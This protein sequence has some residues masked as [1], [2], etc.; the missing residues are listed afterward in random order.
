MSPVAEA[1]WTILRQKNYGIPSVNMPLQSELQNAYASI[2]KK[3]GDAGTPIQPELPEEWVSLANKTAQENNWHNLTRGQ[4][5]N[6]GLCL[7]FGID[8]LIENKQLLLDFLSTC[9]KHK[10]KSLCRALIWTYLYH[11]SKH[12]PG[13]D[14]LGKWLS[15][16]VNEWDWS[17]ADRQKNLKLFGNENAPANISRAVLNIHQEVLTILDSCGLAKNLQSGGMAQ[18][19]FE[20][21]VSNFVSLVKNNEI[22]HV[23]PSLQRILD[24]AAL[25]GTQFSYPRLRD[26]F[27]SNLLEPW[28][29]NIP[30]QEIRKLIQNFL[31]NHF[32]DP[33]LDTSR[34]SG[35][36]D[37]ALNV[38]RS[39]LVERALAQFLDVVDELTRDADMK[40]QW[41]F[42]RAFW[43]SYYEKGF[44]SDAWVAFASNGGYQAKQIA[45]RNQ[46]ESW[47]S[48][49]RLNGQGDSNHAVLILRIGD[50]TV[51]DFSHNGKCRIWNKDNSHAPQPHQA[52]Y[53]R[54]NLTSRADSEFIHQGSEHA[55]WQ[56]KV[57]SEIL[58]KTGVNIS[59][60]EYM[61]K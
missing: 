18:S 51:A 45:K 50:L 6:I 57:A 39:W 20:E 24:W 3:L 10:R 41:R 35:V 46:D 12:K 37:I 58:S 26:F 34:W 4:L 52:M 55:G 22:E 31:L 21:N 48:F 53:I 60:Q 28:N 44:I 61:P 49:G 56:R 32:G 19:A 17:W 16:A 7:F 42:R 30:K 43:M 47:L 54:N 33:R 1:I 11:Y 14:S 59:R 36:S 5:K 27:I 40:H 13:V 2:K 15:N 25:D 38:M 8:P 9:E 23:I 29:T